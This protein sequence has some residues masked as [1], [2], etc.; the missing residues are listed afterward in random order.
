MQVILVK[1][2]K[3]IQ[4]AGLNKFKLFNFAK[5]K[6]AKYSKHKLI[7]INK[8]SNFKPFIFNVKIKL[9]PVKN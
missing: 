1:K 9:Q 3:S 2:I 4:L 8:T 6:S 7:E 5:P